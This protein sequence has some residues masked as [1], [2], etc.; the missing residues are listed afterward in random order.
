MIE[1]EEIIE[2][3]QKEVDG[4]EFSREDS[5]IVE[6]CT[7]E[8]LEIIRQLGLRIEKIKHGMCYLE[9]EDEDQ[10]RSLYNEWL[11]EKKIN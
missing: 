3:V 5:L 4:I 9:L 1:D 11:D 10:F 2:I 7:N 8:A 6:D